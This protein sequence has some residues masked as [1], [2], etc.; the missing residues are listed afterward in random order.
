M[1]KNTKI[2]LDVLCERPKVRSWSTAM[3]SFSGSLPR[4]FRNFTMLRAVLLG[5]LWECA[6]THASP[7]Y[8]PY[9]FQTS[10]TTAWGLKF[11]ALIYLSTSVQDL[12]SLYSPAA[13]YFLLCLFVMKVVWPHSNGYGGN[14]QKSSKICHYCCWQTYFKLDYGMFLTVLVNV[15]II[16]SSF[17]LIEFNEKL[18]CAFKV[19]K[20]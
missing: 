15:C 20:Y 6:R 16:L 8:Y 14:E 9:L 7:N 13:F 18:K 11:F 4:A 3:H 2:K 5:S 12:T 10:L 17:L 1:F 19:V